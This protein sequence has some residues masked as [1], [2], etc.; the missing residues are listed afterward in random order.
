MSVDHFHLILATNPKIYDTRYDLD[1]HIVNFPFLDSDVPRSTS[2][3][4]YISQ[5][6]RFPRVSRYVDCPVMITLN[7]VL[8]AKLLTQSMYGNFN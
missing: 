8:T 6:I 5:L 1:F 4:V 2:Y 3:G 7:N